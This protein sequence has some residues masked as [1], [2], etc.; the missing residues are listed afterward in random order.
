MKRFLEWIKI[1]QLDENTNKVFKA[2]V[3]G[4]NIISWIPRGTGEPYHLQV[5]VQSPRKYGLDREG[6][7]EI[8]KQRKWLEY[9]VFYDELVDA[10]ADRHEGLY[11]T[12][13]ANDWVMVV[14][15]DYGAATV[16]SLRGKDKVTVNA[17][18]KVLMK[19]NLFAKMI[20]GATALEVDIFANPSGGLYGMGIGE[21]ITDVDAWM[22]YVYTGR[23]STRRRLGAELR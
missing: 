12:M 9:P 4:S 11:T 7:E 18:S 23:I 22:S 19:N 16:G 6:I 15:H 20:L 13:F 21:R 3:K 14:V 17:A 1:S 2:W 8:L 5:V 10:E